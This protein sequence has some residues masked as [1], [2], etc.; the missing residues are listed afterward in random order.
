[1]PDLSSPL[2]LSLVAVVLPLVG[3]VLAAL[4]GLARVPKLSH[5]PVILTTGT[6]AVL[7]CY[8]LYAVAGGKSELWETAN[9]GTWFE[10]SRLNA[11]YSFHLD[12]LSVIM[13]A[14]VT[15]IATFIAIFSASYMHGD[16]GYA[17]YFAFIG[18]FVFA[19][20]VLVTANNFF[21]LLLGWEGVGLCSYL[22]V[23]YYY[24]KPSAAAAARK[25]FLVTRLGDVGLVLG[26]FMLWAM[27][28]YHTNIDAVV[29]H[30]AEH[31][32]T[33][34]TLTVACLL[35]FCGAVGKSAQLPLYVWLP[36]AMEGPTPVSALI[37]AATMVTA[38]VYLL[39]R[40][41][42]LFVLSPT[43]Q[44]VVCVIGG[45]TA[46][47]AA[48]IALAQYDLKRVLAYSTVSQLGFMFMALG[49]GGAIAPS[50]AVT[51]A[52]FHLFTHAFFKAL[53]FL[54]SGSVMHAMGNVIDMRK[55]GGLRKLMP[56][57][58]LTFLIGSLALAGFP[59]LS[60]FWSKDQI[61]HGL[62]EAGGGRATYQTVYYA[63]FIT[64]CLTA[65]L[66][67]FYTFRAYFLTFWGEERVP[68]EAH[69]HAH[70]SPRTMLL[71]L[72]VLAIG[73][74]FAGAVVDPL[75]HWFG[76]FLH[77]APVVHE[78]DEAFKRATN[79]KVG[80]HTFDWTIAGVST[81]LALAGIGAAAAVYRKGGPE[82]VPAALRGV[83]SLSANKVYVDEVYNAAVVLPAETLAVGGRQID[84]FLDS[85]ARLVSFLPRFAAALVRPLQ[86]GLIQFY[87]LGMILGLA[88]FLT[89]VVI[90]SVPAR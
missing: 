40:T 1:V 83:H 21:L 8:V 35:L 28:G 36:D 86:N 60:G 68:D 84:A 79:L 80:E 46:L 32:P 70:E 56:V 15:F 74:A 42:P 17:R 67:A 81:A 20:C 72:I 31:P 53:L 58:H 85:L 57:T 82:K 62:S 48:F 27:S 43:A 47:L 52:V 18:L 10:V 49:C 24:A 23:G 63:V 76:H 75:T 55:F 4:C 39:A 65:L 2:G 77:R 33:D 29:T 61:L 41:A 14:T 3:C 30:I 78:A 44:I 11:T 12:P 71:P 64:A 22:L 73:A 54:G 9:L 59:L 89:V 90:R 88:V 37:H 7:A 45:A 87:A 6:A 26:V 38:G 51:A 69:G 16:P 66:T 34:G 13:L 5:L 19:M 25:A 50:L